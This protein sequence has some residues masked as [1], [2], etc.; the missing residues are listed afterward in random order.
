MA[1]PIVF[2]FEETFEVGYYRTDSDY[3]TTYSDGYGEFNMDMQLQRYRDDRYSYRISGHFSSGN[4]VE[5]IGL[6][7]INFT[8]SAAGSILISPTIDWDPP[9]EQFTGGSTIEMQKDE[10]L[11]WSGSA[12]VQFISNSIVQNETVDFILR[13]TVTMGFED[14]YNV[15]LISYVVFFFWF[16]AFPLIPIILKA[17][18]Q[19]QFSAPLDE[20]SI[21]RHKEYLDYF[22]KKTKDD[23]A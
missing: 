22:N 21:E 15:I 7:H 9:T 17:I 12:E 11:T 16:M 18:F 20:E 13:L 4:D 5:I 14:Y 6:K 8:V 23:Q 1:G 19:P 2:N 10:R 3:R